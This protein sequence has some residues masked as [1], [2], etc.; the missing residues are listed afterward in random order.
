MDWR[1]VGRKRNST[2]VADAALDVATP[3]NMS[4]DTYGIRLLEHFS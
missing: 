2:S 1:N 3:R 4:F